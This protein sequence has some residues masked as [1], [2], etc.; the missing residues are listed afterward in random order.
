MPSTIIRPANRPY[1]SNECIYKYTCI[2]GSFYCSLC[3]PCVLIFSAIQPLWLLLNTP[4]ITNG[5]YRQC[6]QC[7]QCI[8]L[9]SHKWNSFFYKNDR[10]KHAFLLWYINVLFI[11][12]RLLCYRAMLRHIATASRPCVCLSVCPSACNVKVLWS[13]SLGY[14]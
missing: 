2:F 11:F 13:Y 7:T 14:M 1:F 4:Q 5:C 10:L 6:T 3:F 9:C 12:I 8:Y